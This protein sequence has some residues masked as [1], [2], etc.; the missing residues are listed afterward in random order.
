MKSIK[1]SKKFLYLLLVLLVFA[2]CRQE[3][4]EVTIY[5][6][7][8]YEAG[9]HWEIPMRIWVH[10]PRKAV[11][12]LLTKIAA[13]LG[14]L[15]EGERK[16]FRFRIEHFVADSR[17]RQDVRFTFDEDENHQELRIKDKDGGYKRSTLNGNIE[18]II[19]IPKEQAQRLLKK[20][21]TTGGW[22]TLR[23][24]SAGHKGTG[25]VRLIKDSGISV[26][27]DIDDTIKI[28]GMTTHDPKIL[29][30]NTFFRDFREAPGMTKMYNEMLNRGY[31][32]HYVSGGPWQLYPPLKGYFI[33]GPGSFPRGSFHMRPIPKN[34]LSISTWKNLHKMVK[35]DSTIELKVANVS[36]ILQHFPNRRFILIGD[37]G[38]KD[39]EVYREIKNQ[40][41]DR[42]MEIRIRD[43]KNDSVNNPERLAGMIIIDPADGQMNTEPYSTTSSSWSSFN[44]L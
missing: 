8:G 44:L 7:Y 27:S 35:G 9:D 25:R 38:E 12:N 39:P 41:G 10:T 40:F 14:E 37:S 31:E 42:V 22:L 32:F 11:E 26:I 1:F 16:N 30:R 33:S 15:S 4:K 18:G 43:V 3:V 23:V 24:I 13:D 29:V 28:T 6:T 19:E 2:A 20:Q 34:L 17:S 5:A 36:R 21:E